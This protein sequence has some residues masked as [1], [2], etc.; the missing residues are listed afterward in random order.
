MFVQTA[1]AY[2]ETETQNSGIGRFEI[3]EHEPTWG[4]LN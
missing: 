4:Q 3:F 2:K 1:S